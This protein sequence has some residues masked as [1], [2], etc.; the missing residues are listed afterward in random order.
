MVLKY[1]QIFYSKKVEG[2]KAEGGIAVRIPSSLRKL[3]D[4]NYFLNHG[5]S[6]SLNKENLYIQVLT[7]LYVV[8]AV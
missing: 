1:Q 4:Q 6:V 3:I 8:K 7:N 5:N 2:G